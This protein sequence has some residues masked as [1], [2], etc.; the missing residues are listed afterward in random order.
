MTETWAICF[1]AVG[2]LVEIAEKRRAHNVTIRPS[3]DR[4]KSDQMMEDLFGF[5]G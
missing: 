4:R 3:N 5:H 1:D 2:S